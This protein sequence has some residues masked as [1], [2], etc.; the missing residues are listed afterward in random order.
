MVKIMT[1]AMVGTATARPTAPLARSALGGAVVADA[2]E[3]R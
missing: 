1:E 2:G 3:E